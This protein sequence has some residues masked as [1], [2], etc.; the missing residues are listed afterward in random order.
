MAK[1]DDVRKEKLKTAGNWLRRERENRG[2]SG[3]AFAER[4]GIGQ[5]RVSSYERGQYEIPEELSPK[6]AE[7]LDLPLLEVRE[8]LGFWVPSDAEL[9]ELRYH[10]DPTQLSDE[11]LITELMQRVRRKSTREIVDAY[12]RRAEVPDALWNRL[13]SSARTEI[14]LAGYTNYF[15]W[16]QQPGFEETLASKLA[17]GVRVRILLGDPDGDVTRHRENIENAPMA[18]SSRIHMTL[19]AVQRLDTFGNLEVR[20]SERNAEAHA[21]RSV[22]QFDR[23]ALVCESIGNEMGHNWLTLHLKKLEDGGPFQRYMEHLEF[24]WDGARVW[25]PSEA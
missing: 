3:T 1:D 24:L 5:V 22:F 14:V 19:A 4:L 11:V 8:G 17:D 12:P 2:L 9:E 13:I 21:L 10:T 16:T 18:L 23:E 20:F 15:F 6:I 7:V 25:E